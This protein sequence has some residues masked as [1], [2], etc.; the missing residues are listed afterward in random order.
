MNQ[1]FKKYG[2]LLSLYLAQSIPMSFFSTVV[3]VIMRQEEYSLTSIGL[4]QLIKIPWILKFL[5]AP[6]IDHTS[7]QRK[8]YRRWILGAE[9]FY[10][11][12]I[13]LVSFFNLST[14]FTTII[15]LVVIAFIA[16]GTQ[17]IATDA[18]AILTLKPGERSMGNSMQSGGSFLGTTLGSGVLLMA[19]YYIGWQ[20]LLLLLAFL[21]TMALMPVTF[22]RL[23]LEKQDLS[24][25]RRPKWDDGFSF[26][27]Q[28]G[29]I[30]HLLLL[31]LYN[32]G[33]IGLLALFK[34]FMVDQGYTTK[35][36]GMISGI[37]GTAVGAIFSLGGGW[38]IRRIKRPVALQIIFLAGF[39]TSLFFVWKMNGE[40]PLWGI[41][42][43]SSMVWGT[44]GLASVFIYT[45]AMDKVR[46]GLEG[47]DFTIQIVITHLSSLFLTIGLSKF[48]NSFGYQ[49][50]YILEAHMGIILLILSRTVFKKVVER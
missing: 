4:I 43:A 37:Y 48:A 9:I 26:F 14:D 32:S 23:P 16:S 5:W 33:I 42:V 3:P 29:N 2:T 6:L 45:V 27:K 31:F 10:A 15:I 44:Y 47:T 40:V 19:Y 39:L 22:A 49:G 24:S 7:P 20:A 18:F 38:L 11:M 21:V 46:P 1:A 35:E 12:V 30:R 8:H 41:Y 17:D 13:V 50:M 28:K 34:P 36:I 25:K